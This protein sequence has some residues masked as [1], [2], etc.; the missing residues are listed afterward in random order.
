MVAAWRGPARSSRAAAL[1]AD[2][3]RQA[4]RALDAAQAKLQAGA[5]DSAAALVAMAEAGPP[6]EHRPARIDLLPAQ[7]AF[8]QSP[9][10]AAP[11]PLLGAAHRP[12]PL[13]TGT[14]SDAPPR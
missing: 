6:D 14:A 11:P 4:R 7:I 12:P 9:G 10:H 3:A 2:P 1:P 8:L 5:F 13:G